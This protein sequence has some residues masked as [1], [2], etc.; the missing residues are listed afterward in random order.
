MARRRDISRSAVPVRPVPPP[1]PD[2]SW[3]AR[4]EGL[5]R[6]RPA[7]LAVVFALLAFLVMLAGWIAVLIAPGGNIRGNPIFWLLAAPLVVWL[8]SMQSFAAWT[9]RTLWLVLV[10]AP[11]LALLA[12]VVAPRM[13]QHALLDGGSTYLDTPLAMTVIL[14][15]TTALAGAGL[16]ALRRSSLPGGTRPASYVAPGVPVPGARTLSTPATNMLTLGSLSFSGTLING[17]FFAIVAT[18]EPVG[19]GGTVWPT[20][21][22]GTL[23]LTVGTLMFRG[24]F[25]LVR[26]REGASADLRRG[27]RLGIGCAVSAVVALWAWPTILTAKLGL[28]CFMVPIAVA[29]AWAGRN[30]LRDLREISGER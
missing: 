8:W 10:L 27:W 7:Q 12:L 14:G 9:V 22:V 17:I 1:P 18:M 6:E 30:A 16:V 5:K 24:A 28:S 19:P 11:C 4:A 13:R 29:A 20:A 21:L 3:A 25:R 26:H 2:R 15:L 23:V